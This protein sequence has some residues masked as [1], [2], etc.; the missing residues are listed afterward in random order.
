MP[1]RPECFGYGLDRISK[2][3]HQLIVS[4]SKIVHDFYLGAER[5]QAFG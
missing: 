1:D 5:V 2:V 4:A 3:I